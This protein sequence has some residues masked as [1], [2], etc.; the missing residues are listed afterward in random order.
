[1]DLGWN[2]ATSFVI[3][4]YAHYDPTL[5]IVETFASSHLDFTATATIIKD[6]IEKQYHIVY[7]VVDGANKQG[8]EEMNRRHSLCLQP[9][10]K[11][12]K[13]EAIQMMNSDFVAQNIKILNVPATQPLREEYDK[14]VW[15][16]QT[17]QSESPKEDPGCSNH[18]TDAALYAFRAA[19]KYMSRNKPMKSY[20]KG[21]D[22][23]DEQTY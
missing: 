16:K 13:Y 22:Y 6:K 18:L 5:Y 11:Q 7:K 19:Q 12:G 14:L 1:M 8:V 10:E 2:D 15:A 20:Y 3:A 21:I 23:D 4:A 17:N 9:A